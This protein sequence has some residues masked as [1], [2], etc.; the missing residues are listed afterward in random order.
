[1]VG[2]HNMTP[3]EYQEI[4]PEQKYAI[5]LAT[6][7]NPHNPQKIASS[8]VLFAE[9]TAYNFAGPFPGGYA[10]FTMMDFRISSVLYR[11]DRKHRKSPIVNVTR[12]LAKA[13]SD[14]I[15]CEDFPIQIA[16]YGNDD[17]AY[18]AEFKTLREAI[19]VWNILLENQ[20]LHFKNDFL[21]FGF[22]G[23]W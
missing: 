18:S 22:H 3:E 12:H 17:A 10:V 1:M 19:E 8:I 13:G 20:P 2:I 7:N 21:P 5:S 6:L 15:P 11:K 4:Y 16:A 9:D 23:M 14:S